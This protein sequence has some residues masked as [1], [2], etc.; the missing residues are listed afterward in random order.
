MKEYV[1]AL[2]TC[3]K[4]ADAKR[5]ATALVRERLAACVNVVPGVTSIYTWKGKLC[6]DRELLLVIK[7]RSDKGAALTR[8]VRELHPYSVPEVIQLP[9]RA[10]SAPYLRWIDETVG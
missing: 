1:V 8:R 2:V 9:V 3:G 7:T 10:G 5:L 4:A 6:R